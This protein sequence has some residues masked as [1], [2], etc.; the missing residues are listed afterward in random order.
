MKDPRV[1]E[2]KSR[3]QES[4]VPALQRSNS[5]ETSKKAR[6][7]KKKNNR[8]NKRDCRAQEGPIPAI[9]DNTTDPDNSKKKKNDFNRRNPSKVICY[10][11]NKKGHYSNKG[12][13]HQ[14]QK[15]S[16]GLGNLHI[17]DWG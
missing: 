9:G 13:S 1:E 12:L 7:E 14:S 5:A 10:N 6:K 17:G 15:T 3:L 16:T 8:R 11:Y 4:K 2:P